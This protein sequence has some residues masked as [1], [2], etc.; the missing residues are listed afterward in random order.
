MKRALQ[1]KSGKSY[2]LG[3]TVYPDG[4]NFS[5]FSKNCEAVE[6][7]LFEKADEPPI[8][9]IALDP[10]ENR[11][12]YYWHVFIKGL[13]PGQLYGYRVY[14]PFDPGQGHRFDGSKLLLDPYTKAVAFGDNYDRQA[15]ARDGD[16]CLTAMKSVV[17][18]TA[19]YDWEGDRPLEHPFAKS[20][21]YELH[22]GGFTK[23]PNSGLPSHKRGTF[24]GLVQKIPYLKA[25]GITSVE[26]LPVQ[27]FDK[28]DVAI[29]SLSNYWGYSP[30][31]LFAP[32]NDYCTCK[33]PITLINE[34]RD[35]VKALHQAGI[36]V[37]LDVIFNHTAEGDHD[38]PTISFK[39]LENR[40]YYMLEPNR[41]LY[42]DFSGTGNSLNANHSIVRRMIIDC[43]RYW[44]S[45]MH[46]D[47]FR[48]DLAS[49]LS[50]GEA[51]NPLENP[52]I[53]WSIESDPVLASSKII[54]EAWDAQGLYQL[55]SFIGHK[56]AEWNGRYRDEIR[57]F[58][59][60]DDGMAVPTALRIAGSPD[61][62][63]EVIRDPN[64]SINFTTSHDGF[65]LSD[66]V[67]YNTKHNLENGEKN[68][69]GTN[70]NFSWN[71]GT[72]GPSKDKV[73]EG[74]RL[75]QI[76][77][78]LTILML[79]QGTPMLAMGD[80]VRRTQGG[81]NNPYN[82]D[83]EISWFDWDLVKEH[84]Y[85][86]TFVQQLIRFNLSQPF[87]QEK[88]YWKHLGYF[89][90]N[91][92]HTQVTWHGVQLGLPDWSHY[93]HTLSYSLESPNHSQQLHVIINMYW[94]ALTFE[95]PKPANR[96]QHWR[97][98]I[99]TAREKKETFLPID[100]AAKVRSNKFKVKERSVV[101]L[102]LK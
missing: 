67:A 37:I 29:P 33:D 70:D 69:D 1:I 40:A 39:G 56:W 93:S 6:L 35:M 89:D 60:G 26:L 30:I 12:F 22:V 75:R 2:P 34:F 85:L 98:I 36:E 7:L 44:V 81:N 59:R 8:Q 14:G 87:F 38:G 96:D 58:M 42:T 64:R 101:V 47:G 48:F 45:E 79:S 94:E 16:N 31:A 28:Q 63:Q 50:R 21:I 9:V 80:E 10:E 27:Q 92:S 77:N 82:Q 54:A 19:D 99:D 49:V 15:A 3:A 43:L 52:P 62:F 74:L 78:F 83:N 84:Q 32:H 95:I 41:N 65:T 61:L 23:H 17:I 20:V 51:G 66:L 102:I 68:T 4:V 25:L 57:R 46:V 73:I 53:L 18:D 91:Y 71:H 11:T 90:H 86:L 72:E 5:L 100:K 88:H 76:K 13:R 97:R 55:G 24:S